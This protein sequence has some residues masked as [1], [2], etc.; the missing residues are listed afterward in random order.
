MYV[1]KYDHPPKNF[2]MELKRSAN[3][4]AISNPSELSSGSESAGEGM[5]GE[6]IAGEGIAGE[7]T[8]PFP[9]SL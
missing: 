1:R 8:G 6:G 3:H 9:S 2:E 4:F 5:A 7:E